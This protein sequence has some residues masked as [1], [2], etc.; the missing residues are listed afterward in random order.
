MGTQGTLHQFPT[1]V[2]LFMHG[3]VRGWCTG[4]SD[5]GGGALI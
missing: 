1:I 2:S 4:C 3:P 5:E